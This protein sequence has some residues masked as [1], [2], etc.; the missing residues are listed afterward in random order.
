MFA[1]DKQFQT[2]VALLQ[3]QRTKPLASLNDAKKADEDK[4]KK[5]LDPFP[6]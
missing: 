2:R 1:N 4:A 5:A 3:V 6:S